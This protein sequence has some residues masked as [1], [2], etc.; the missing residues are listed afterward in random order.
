MR[1]HRRDDHRERFGPALAVTRS[2]GPRDA[3]ENRSLVI[4][5][6]V[7]RKRMK[8]PPRR[9][10][11]R[12]NRF[13][14]ELR[15]RRSSKSRSNEF[16]SVSRCFSTRN[17]RTAKSMVGSL[18]YSPSRIVVD[19]QCRGIGVRITS[20][21]TFQFVRSRTTTT[22]T[23]NVGLDG[24]RNAISINWRSSW[25]WI[26]RGD[27]YRFIGRFFLPIPV[28]V[29]SLGS[30]I[31]T[32]RTF[33]SRPRNTNSKRRRLREWITESIAPVCPNARSISV[34][35]RVSNIRP[36]QMEVVDGL[37]S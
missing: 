2:T 19:V 36:K 11:P 20:R 35:G 8:R 15:P 27:V 6:F 4:L 9:R 21:R 7:A 26:R 23:T 13:V 28:S 24:S 10:E 37:D 14:F 17:V 33:V 34:L 32:I 3:L 25:R 18:W 31:F 5:S 30:I 16:C 12:T 29:G 1:F 22:T